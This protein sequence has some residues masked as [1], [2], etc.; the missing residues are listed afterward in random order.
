M[1]NYNK[2]LILAVLGITLLFSDYGREK[3]EK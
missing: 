1:N 3:I 2:T